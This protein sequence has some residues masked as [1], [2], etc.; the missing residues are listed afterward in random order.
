MGGVSRCE[1]KTTLVM[2][3]H[4][5]PAWSLAR[6]QSLICFPSVVRIRVEVRTEQRG[7]RGMTF[8]T[9]LC[10]FSSC[11]GGSLGAL[12]SCLINRLSTCYLGTGLF[13]MGNEPCVGIIYSSESFRLLWSHLLIRDQ[14]HD[15]LVDNIGHIVIMCLP[16]Q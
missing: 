13:D 6:R 15:L 11:L 12:Y 9:S 10:D 7:R 16:N 5:S 3:H 2:R 14:A 4:K 1:P 8:V